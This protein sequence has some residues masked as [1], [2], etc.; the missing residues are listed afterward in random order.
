VEH[1]MG[2]VR[3]IADKVTVLHQGRVLA[4]GQLDEL[5]VD[6]TVIEVYLGTNDAYH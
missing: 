2:F 3:S 4:E 5:Q 1:D 6:P